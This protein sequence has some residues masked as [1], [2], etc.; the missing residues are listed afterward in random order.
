MDMVKVCANL[1]PARRTRP[2]SRRC[3]MGAGVMLAADSRDEG[4][5]VQGRRSLMTGIGNSNPLGLE[6]ATFLYRP[7]LMNATLINRPGL[8]SFVV[9]RQD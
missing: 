8:S 7:K 9:L 3:C 2:A 5:Y 4:M 1:L 6:V